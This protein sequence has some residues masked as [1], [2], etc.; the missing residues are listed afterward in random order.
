[1]K[2]IK[3][4]VSNIASYKSAEIDFEAINYPVAIYG[5]NGA[6]KTT[7]F[8]DAVT[9]ALYGVAYGSSKLL[10]ELRG[11][12]PTGEVAL[13][14][15]IEG[16]RYKVVRRIH[17]DKANEA[18]LYTLSNGRWKP[19]AVGTSEVNNKINEII[20]IDYRALMNSAIV[21]QGEVH[22]L[23]EA[24][25][26]DRVEILLKLLK[27]DLSRYSD[28]AKEKVKI[29]SN[30]LSELN[31]KKVEI[32]RNIR[33]EERIKNKVDELSSKR[34]EVNIKIGELSK[35]LA[36]YRNLEE[37]IL[38]ELSEINRVIGGLE[39]LIGKL[40]QLEVSINEVNDKLKVFRRKFTELKLDI[41]LIDKMVKSWDQI[42]S[43][44][45][46]LDEI[47]G[48]E[49]LI[50][51]LNELKMNLAKE[52]SLNKLKDELSK[53]RQTIESLSNEKA[54]IQH[55]L[56]EVRKDIELLKQA[57][58]YCP[59][60]GAKLTKE[61]KE[62]RLSSLNKQVTQ[63]EDELNALNGEIA[64][65][66]SLAARIEEE[67]ESIS[68]EV[69][70]AKSTMLLL[71]PSSNIDLEIETK[72]KELNEKIIMR[73]KLENKIK[74]TLPEIDIDTILKYYNEVSSNVIN[75]R[76]Y[77]KL[78]DEL[79]KLQNEHQ[80]LL[81][82]VS[83][84][85]EKV[86]IKLSLEAK[87]VDIKEKISKLDEELDKLK[88]KLGK[89]NGELEI[90]MDRLR[91]ISQDKERLKEITN[92]IKDVETDIEAYKILAETFSWRGLPLALLRKYL[93]DINY[94]TN[95]YLED[96]EQNISMKLEIGEE[97]GK[98]TVELIT[99]RDNIKANPNTLSNGEKILLGF[100]LR[101][102]LN[103][104]IS[105]I[106]YGGK[107]PRFF[108]IDEGFGP[109]DSD[110]RKRVAW[111]LY[112]LIRDGKYDQL[113]IISHAEGLWEEE[114]FKTRIEVYKEAGISKINI[115]S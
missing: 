32:E 35:E 37:R 22:E 88:E 36:E 24:K 59:L 49:S 38:S 90:L 9:A 97:A 34:D 3:L 6:G 57:E 91:S 4:S 98:P 83:T 67:I 58:T 29:L 2:L 70:E 16:V 33:E 74:S 54:V 40:H 89:V 99:Y 51:K 55:K 82:E 39:S 103:D 60:C 26:A 104:I 115:L 85:Q 8:V 63:L 45:S 77:E 13:E 111:A 19:L 15:E 108:I 72:T 75:I 25:R 41:N 7:L 31:G 84:Y 86:Q 23:I 11:R 100:A 12:S 110:N 112:T 30:R 62:S 109:L 5:D 68:K 87:L 61:H 14:F 114:I 44:S 76:E 27:F 64:E 78:L 47:D 81:E 48:L 43:Y 73:N 28:E 113:L 106:Y 56:K 69:S 92:E 80:I 79:E 53:L 50:S 20:G 93:D 65:R 10:N 66:T 71:C 105:R 95:R 107:R 102:A 101:L 94:L 46:C 52:E 17:R 18:Y 21:R 96:F 42:E 1:M